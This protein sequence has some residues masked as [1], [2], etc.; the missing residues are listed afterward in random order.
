MDN[1]ID[2]LVRI[3]EQNTIEALAQLEA[4]QKSY[5]KA[6]KRFQDLKLIQQIMKN[7]GITE[8]TL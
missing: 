5:D 7:H 6:C 8:I 2:F 4:A 1:S 3:E